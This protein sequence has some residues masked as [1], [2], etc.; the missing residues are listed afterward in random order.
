M[1]EAAR[2][3]DNLISSSYWWKVVDTFGSEF[4][5]TL[6]GRVRGDMAFL[7]S[8]GIIQMATQLLP[9]IKHFVIKCGSKG[10]IS[11]AGATFLY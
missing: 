4:H 11:S 10:G 9:F 1:W 6:S 5:Q 2:A 8:D 3:E 7:L